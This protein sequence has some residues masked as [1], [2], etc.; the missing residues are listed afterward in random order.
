MA[1]HKRTERRGDFI[2]KCSFAVTQTTSKRKRTIIDCFRVQSPPYSPAFLQ[3]TIQMQIPC[4]P[5][6]P[7][8]SPDRQALRQL[9]DMNRV[10]TNQRLKLVAGP[11]V[12]NNVNK[13]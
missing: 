5:P 3:S 13:L 6:L 9:S 4:G 12:P 10:R 7:S 8:S 11:N 2:F 1:A